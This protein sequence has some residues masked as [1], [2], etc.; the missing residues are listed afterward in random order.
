MRIIQGYINRFP[1]KIPKDI[2]KSWKK[3]KDIF[4]ISE[5]QDIV[6]ELKY[7][8]YIHNQPEQ[9]KLAYFTI[10]E[11]NERWINAQGLANNIKSDEAMN[12]L[13]DECGIIHSNKL[14]TEPEYRLAFYTIMKAFKVKTSNESLIQKIVAKD[15]VNATVEEAIV[16]KYAD[17]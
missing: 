15:W 16:D 3:N 6:Q 8:V 11:T 2:I 1:K 10:L 9:L 5:L 12:D 17:L 13:I 14:F 7:S 4:T